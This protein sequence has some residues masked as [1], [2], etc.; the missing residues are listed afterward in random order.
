M[1][2]Y[3]SS[4]ETQRKLDERAADISN[5]YNK[6][7]SKKEEESHRLAMQQ[8]IEEQNVLLDRVGNQVT[9]IGDISKELNKE[10]D[11]HNRI[12][13]EYQD[14]AN[15]A[16]GRLTAANKYVDKLLEATKN[17]FSWV[18]IIGLSLLLIFS[19][20]VIWIK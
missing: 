3:L 15:E 12:L 16:H 18:L 1:Q 9:V 13:I 19:M 10:L 11:E 8:M 7:L 5:S 20:L 6:G 17:H 4:A 14:E 2:K